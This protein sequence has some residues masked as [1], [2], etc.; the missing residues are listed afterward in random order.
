MSKEVE[1]RRLYVGLDESNHGRYPEFIVGVSS[2]LK[3]DAVLRTINGRERMRDEE[4]VRFL[5]NEQRRYRGVRAEKGQ[6]PR[7]KHQLV[8]AGIYLVEKLLRENEKEYGRVDRLDIFLDGDIRLHEIDRLHEM[9][10]GLKVRAAMGICIECYPK[11]ERGEYEYP[12]LL[13]AA[14]SLVHALFREHSFL[15]RL[16]AEERMIKLKR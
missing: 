14:D 16:K 7:N 10:L 12:R 9:L 6:I 2:F 4:I 11:K 13:V 15:K 3:S 8:E 5:E 1:E